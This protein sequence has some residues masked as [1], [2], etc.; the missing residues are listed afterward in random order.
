[1][2]EDLSIPPPDPEHDRT[3]V[4]D[5]AVTQR[6]LPLL[7]GMIA[8][9][10]EDTNRSVRGDGDGDGGINGDTNRTETKRKS[11]A[12]RF[13][14]PVLAPMVY[15]AKWAVKPRNR[16]TMIGYILAALAW[17]M[18]RQTLVLVAMGAAMI[19]Q[20]I[21]SLETEEQRRGFLARLTAVIL[22]TCLLATGI[23]NLVLHITAIHIEFTNP[24]VA[25]SLATL[26]TVSVDAQSAAVPGMIQTDDSR[27]MQKYTAAQY[28]DGTIMRIKMELEQF[29]VNNPAE[30]AASTYDIGKKWNH[31]CLAYLNRTAFALKENVTKANGA[32]V[33]IER[34]A[35]VTTKWFRHILFSN[36]PIPA[37]V[38]YSS[39]NP[40]APDAVTGTHSHPHDRNLGIQVAKRQEMASF[41]KRKV[42]RAV[43]RYTCITMTYR[44]ENFKVHDD[45]KFCDQESWNIQHYWAVHS[46]AWVC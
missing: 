9:P 18:T 16:F 7:H 22:V 35:F 38:S 39:A 14:V 15:A 27:S 45:V 26:P 44:D 31:L 30:E 28:A 4:V 13:L 41:C 32:V 6:R 43:D 17:F 34:E 37:E 2:E 11:Y 8:D 23:R 25:S 1:M 12:L 24:D 19:I 10:L 40:H 5:S 33:E 21:R 42:F 20:R 46:G 36:P 29:L 3:L